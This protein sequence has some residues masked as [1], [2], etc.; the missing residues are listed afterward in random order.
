MALRGDTA[1]V[2]AQGNEDQNGEGS[3]SAYVFTRT[4]DGWNQEAILAA[5]DGGEHDSFGSS[6]AF[7]GDTILVGANTDDEPNGENGGSAYVFTR[8]GERWVQQTKL[9]ADDGDER[10]NFGEAAALDDDTAF[11]G[12][13]AD[14]DPL[15]YFAGSAYVYWKDQTEVTLDIEPGSDRNPVDPAGEGTIPVAIVR[16]DSFDPTTGVDVGSLRFGAPDIVDD[17][18][19]AT[20]VHDG[21]LEDVTGDGTDDLLLHFPTEDAGFERDDE[22]GELVG[23]TD[24]GEVIFGMD[25]VETAGGAGEECNV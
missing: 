20:P 6:V 1:V 10:D 13:Y 19:G 7:D 5:A 15:G 12:A 18:E 14:E 23:E 24:E 8:E 22:A 4:A 21:H 11:V 9:A 3:G 2:S 16:T 25:R 17:G